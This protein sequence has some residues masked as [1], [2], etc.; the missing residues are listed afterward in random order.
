MFMRSAAF[1]GA[2]T[3]L[4]G[5]LNAQTANPDVTV[6]NYALGLENLEVAFFVQGLTQFSSADFANSNFIQNFGSVIGGDV[7]AYLSL[8]RDQDEQH[9]RTL[10]SLISSLGGTPVKPCAYA[11]GYKTADDFATAAA[12]LKN[13]AVMAYNGA[14][15]QFQS[16]SI[17]TTAATL[18]SV[19]ARHASYLNLLIGPSPFPA[20]FDSFA[21]SA[22]TAAALAQYITAC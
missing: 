3:L 19:D 22:G 21:T 8:I 1:F 17:K 9:V 5:S 2:A 14:L 13:T 20:S 18:A 12:A 16:L 11:F 10:K 15:Y 4:S 7:Y 6:L